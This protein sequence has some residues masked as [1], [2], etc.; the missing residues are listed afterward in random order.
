MIHSGR[1]NRELPSQ[2]WKLIGKTLVMQNF[3]ALREFH[4]NALFIG[5]MHFMD[6]A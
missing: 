4:W 1:V 2:F 5:T 6:K 3:D